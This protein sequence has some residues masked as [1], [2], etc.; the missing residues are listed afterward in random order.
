MGMKGYIKADDHQNTSAQG[1]YAL[2][3]V[4]GKVCVYNIVAISSHHYAAGW[5]GYLTK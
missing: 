1:V 3:D 2:G 4:C 5:T